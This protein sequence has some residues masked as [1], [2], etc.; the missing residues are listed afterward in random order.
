MAEN[1]SLDLTSPNARRWNIVKNAA[2]KGESGQQVAELTRTI[3]LRA[4]RKVLRQ[5]EEYGVTTA[6]FLDRKGSSTA[7]KALLRQT[8][9]HPYAE[10]LVSVID[11]YPDAPLKDCLQRWGHAILDKVF[12][13][14]S[15]D[16]GGSECFPSFFDTSLFFRE[17]RDELRDDLKKVAVRLAQDPRWK[18]TVR[19]KKGRAKIDPTS[20]Q[21]H[22]SLIGGS[23][24]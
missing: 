12:D 14:I 18:P 22:V 9:N 4:I 19:T 3:F 10:L 5:F 1:E 2:R 6:D 15:L 7:I 16:L 24:R 20:S 23:T 13:Q 21:L 17:V 8:K 11:A